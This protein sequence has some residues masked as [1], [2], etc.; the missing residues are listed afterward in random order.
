V[1]DYQIVLGKFLGA[2]CFLTLVILLSVYMPLLVM[3]HGKISWGQVFAGYLG[4]LLLGSATLAIGTFGSSM[5]RSQIVAVVVSA[6]LWGVMT[7]SWRLVKVTDAPLD[8]IFSYLAL[9]NI[10]FQSFMKG[11]VHL[12]D[13]VYYLSVTVVFLFASTRMMES[14]RWR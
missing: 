13:I 8:D 3:V 11:K 10:H 9:H 5:T 4:V 12:R 2:W 7:Q 1:K 6:F 14:R